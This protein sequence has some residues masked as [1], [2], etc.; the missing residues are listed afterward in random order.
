[1][2]AELVRPVGRRAAAVLR[3][4]GAARH[5]GRPAHEG[6]LHQHPGLQGLQR[7]TSPLGVYRCIYICVC[8]CVCIY[9]YVCVCVC[10]CVCLFMDLFR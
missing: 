1:M 7:Y 6:G 4:R 8:V 9:I 2:E 10:V 3:G 5:G